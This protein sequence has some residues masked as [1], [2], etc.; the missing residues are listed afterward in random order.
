M[1]GETLRESSL[2]GMRERMN[3]SDSSI[4]QRS[5]KEKAA[6]RAVGNG[7]VG[8]HGN[9]ELRNGRSHP[10]P[11]VREFKSS[12]RTDG[13][14]LAQNNSLLM[15]AYQLMLPVHS[16][17]KM[18]DA[19]RGMDGWTSFEEAES[20]IMS[21]LTNLESRNGPKVNLLP[22]DFQKK[23]VEVTALH[24]DLSLNARTAWQQAQ[25]IQQGPQ[26]DQTQGK[27]EILARYREFAERHEPTLTQMVDLDQVMLK[28]AFMSALIPKHNIVK[29]NPR[30]TS[31]EK[32]LARMEYNQMVGQLRLEVM[33]VLRFDL[34]K[35]VSR[36]GWDKAKSNYLYGK[37]NSD[38]HVSFFV[39]ATLKEKQ[40]QDPGAIDYI[41]EALVGT[42][43]R[44][45]HITKTFLNDITKNSSLYYGKPHQKKEH[46]ANKISEEENV[47]MTKRLEDTV[48]KFISKIRND[49]MAVKESFNL[50][51]LV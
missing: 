2:R 17:K 45:I 41:I 10:R 32:S 35:L 25:V 46:D 8:G 26:G 1:A 14:V 5:E 30:L 28:K 48:S 29:E 24:Q 21:L 38:F 51:T 15:R 18:V 40:I 36:Y 3:E 33:D 9:D 44:A 49:L 50:G 43:W 23:F 11:L 37:A 6:G 19:E 42:E 27:H 47:K 31:I 22:P 12:G 39:P 4:R 20:R 13:A 7:G 16:G 34:Q